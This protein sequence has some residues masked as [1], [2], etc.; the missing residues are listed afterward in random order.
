MPLILFSWQKSDYFR[1]ICLL[2]FHLIDNF[3]TYD[4]KYF[5]PLLEKSNFVMS[6][7]HCADYLKKVVPK[8]YT[9]KTTDIGKP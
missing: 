3:I 2:G 1:Q 4:E 9:N 5:V 7:K 8:E 6:L